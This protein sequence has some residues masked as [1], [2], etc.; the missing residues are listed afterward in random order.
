MLSHV[1]GGCSPVDELVHGGGE[2]P[3]G[4]AAVAGG[5]EVQGGRRVAI[6]ILDD[7]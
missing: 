1:L 3:D 6:E 4:M 7:F 5:L 2:N